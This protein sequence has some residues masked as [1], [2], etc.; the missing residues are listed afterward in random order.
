MKRWS[1]TWT[2]GPEELGNIRD[3]FGE[4][5]IPFIATINIRY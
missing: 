1:T 5:V 3:M 4:K 2:L